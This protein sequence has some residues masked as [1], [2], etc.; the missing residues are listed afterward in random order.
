MAQEEQ[1]ILA[2]LQKFGA[3][4]TAKF[5]ALASGQPED[6]LRA[7]LETMLQEVGTALSMAVVAKGESL[8]ADRLGRP[9]YAILVNRLLAG[10]VELKEPGK[11][12][13]PERY[14]GH[15]REQWERF[16]S[17]PNL[18]YTDG[19]EWALYWLGEREGPVV[20]LKGDVTV[21]G[22]SAASKENADGL[23]MLL[24]AFLTWTPIVPKDA[25]GLADYL[26]PLC[27]LLRREVADSLSNSSSPLHQLAKDWR[28]LL[29]PDADDERFADAY[30]QTVTFAL[31]LARSE[32]ASTLEEDLN[33]AINQLYARHT[34]LSR[35]LQVLTDRSARDE[36]GPPLRLLQRVIDAV[37]PNAMK[38]TPKSDPW[39]YFYEEFLGAYDPQLRKNAGVYYTP[40]E[41]VRAQVRMIDELL[42]RRL[43]KPKGFAEEGVITLDPAVGTGTYLLGVVDHALGRTANE[44]GAGAVP[45]A[46][47]LLAKQVYGFE[48]MT[49]PYAVAELRVSRSI[50]DRGGMLPADGPGV[51]LTDTLESPTAQAPQTTF[52]HK[53]IAEQHQRALRV[54]GSVPV[55][56][57]LGNPP[58]DRHAAAAPKSAES[59]AKTGGWIRWGD[60]GRP[61]DAIL[62]DFTATVTKRGQLKNMYNL[63]VYFWRWALWKVFEHTTATGPGVVSYISASSYMDGDAFAG[64]REWMRR[65]CDEIWIIDLGGEGRGT[66][67]SENVF[68]IQTPV[69]IAIAVRE[70]PPSTVSPAKVHIARIDGSR[71]EKLGQLDALSSITDLAWQDCPT[72][73]QAPFRPAGSGSY[74]E[75]PLLTDLFPWQHSGVQLKRLWPI[76]PDEQTLRERWKQ[77]LSSTD[78]AAAFR[79]TDDRRIGRRYDPIPPSTTIEPAIGQLRSGVPV[80]FIRPY[81]YRSFDRQFIIADG[82]LM[83]RP[84]PELWRA[85]SDQ[86]MYVT[87]LLHSP[88]GGGPALTAAAHLPDLH[89]FRGSFGDKGAIP[90]YRTADG[91]SPN[92]LAGLLGILSAEY[93][94]EVESEDLLAYVYGALAHPAFTRR[95]HVELENRELRVPLTKDAE[96]FEAAAEVGRSLLWLHTYGERYSGTSRPPRSIPPGRA[97]NTVAVPGTAA[98]Y[99][100]SFRYDENGGQ[101][102]VGTGVFAP[103]AKEVYE[104]GVSGLKVVQSWLTYR[105]PGGKGKGSSPLDD[106]RPEKW[107]HQFTT[108]LLELLWVLEATI[109]GYPAQEQLLDAVLAGPLFK[110][111]ELPPVPPSARQAPSAKAQGTL[112]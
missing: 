70:G 107:T 42:V 43:R 72:G 112:L 46:A 1:Q 110:A 62:N 44:Q 37:A 89:H 66:R 35:A 84:R 93:G 75:S 95:F 108:E 7:P 51:Y 58:Y 32:G 83:S 6:Q 24:R 16:K 97:R 59:R 31:L 80:P 53:D 13:R 94:Q 2:A 26:A 90:L 40:V 14:K 91:T 20:R 56:V 86:Q 57:C 38:A 36:I 82:R 55:L 67:Q 103:V 21:D 73:W 49:G 30:A 12:A 52:F 34:L 92:V 18:L 105:M 78:R 102:I 109:T 41:V 63:Y 76:A 99:P 8:L 15:D 106:V 17:L 22:T 100:Q 5:G 61:P 96:L 19:N 48:I 85:H 33:P 77:L 4:V 29:F 47:S 3:S 74:F 25:K 98:G 11:G 81:S 39:L 28:S 104:F 10:H 65:Q 101:L 23:N 27:R 88:L 111:L 69:A 54:K 60:S 64:M 50:V 68:A 71:E 45:G 9:D 79:E 87:T